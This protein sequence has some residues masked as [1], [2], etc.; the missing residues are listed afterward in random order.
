MSTQ[1]VYVK[2]KSWEGGW[3]RCRFLHTELTELNSGLQPPQSWLLCVTNEGRSIRG[4]HC[5]QNSCSA[6]SPRSFMM[7]NQLI[8]GKKC[9]SNL[10]LGQFGQ[11]PAKR[12]HRQEG[13]DHDSLNW[14]KQKNQVK[15][16]WTCL[17]TSLQCRTWIYHLQCR[18]RRRKAPARSPGRLSSC[19]FAA[20]DAETCAALW[21][22]GCPIWK[23]TVKIRENDIYSKESDGAAG[24]CVSVCVSHWRKRW[25]VAAPHIHT[26]IYL[27]PV[28]FIHRVG[29]LFTV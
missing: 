3:T 27:K 9:S 26:D 4:W 18:G 23:N 29:P 11:R 19:S 22:A 5:T 14:Q 16:S 21:F 15:T 1:R 12:N 10:L 13:G 28:K 8:K 7:M 6:E 20:A 25:N 17:K 24:S 2:G